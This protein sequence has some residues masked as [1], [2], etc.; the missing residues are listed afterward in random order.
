MGEEVDIAII[1]LIV[2]L[3]ALFVTVNQLLTQLFG[4]ADGYRRC[5][6]SVIDVW[7]V[8]R[9]RVWKWSEFRF[10]TR[11]VTPQIWLASPGE[12]Q[13]YEDEYEG[14][15]LIN[16]PNLN[17]DACK[18][19]DRTVH[20]EYHHYRRSRTRR[21]WKFMKP[22]AEDSNANKIND[23]EKAN[24]SSK[25][26]RARTHGALRIRTQSDF[27]VSRLLLLKEL[28]KLS[29]SYWPDDCT[30]CTVPLG[31]KMIPE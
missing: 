27:L 28:H 1:A 20:Q 12:I 30:T 23:V 3:I 8:K 11:Y 16:S 4:S 21:G 6:E 19:L 13:D 10:E 25:P 2:S 9:H 31:T 26:R 24:V 18:E 14:I 15:F 7:H 5:A 22:P 17:D 29:N